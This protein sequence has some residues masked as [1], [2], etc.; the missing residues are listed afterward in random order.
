MTDKPIAAFTD[1]YKLGLIAAGIPDGPK[2]G[3]M[4][5]MRN[6]DE[7]SASDNGEQGQITVIADSDS[8]PLMMIADRLRVETLSVERLIA[9]RLSAERLKV[10][11]AERGL[12]M[13]SERPL[14]AISERLRVVDQAEASAASTI[15]AQ[16][17]A[18]VQ[19]EV[20]ADTARLIAGQYKRLG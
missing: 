14:M 12:M 19:A 6:D 8:D 15:S 7:N 1:A 17:L 10:M 5:K 20:V 18:E 9:E 16:R 2:V 3:P 11:T 4:V 13:I